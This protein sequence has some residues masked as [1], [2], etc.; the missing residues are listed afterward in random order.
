MFSY[1]TFHITFTFMPVNTKE[2]DT[3]KYE[4]PKGVVLT[5]ITVV[6]EGPGGAVII[7]QDNDHL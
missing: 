7:V 5:V 3:E 1:Y 2:V 6:Y 4:G